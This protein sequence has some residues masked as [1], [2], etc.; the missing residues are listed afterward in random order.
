MSDKSEFLEEVEFA[1]D[2]EGIYIDDA[3]LDMME[4]LELAEYPVSELIIDSI[5]HRLF[6]QYNVVIDE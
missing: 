3:T 4:Q 1:L 2:S 6:M 5:R